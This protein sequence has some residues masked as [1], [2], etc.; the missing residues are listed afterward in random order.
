MIS[1]Y[2]VAKGLVHRTTLLG[3]SVGNFPLPADIRELVTA[4]VPSL[5]DTYFT[6]VY[7]MVYPGIVCQFR[8]MIHTVADLVNNWNIKAS[9]DASCTKHDL[10]MDYDDDNPHHVRLQ[11]MS[12]WTVHLFVNSHGYLGCWMPYEVKIM[13]TTFYSKLPVDVAWTTPTPIVVMQ[14]RPVFALTAYIYTKKQD[15][16]F[17][18]LNEDVVV[19]AGFYRDIAELVACMNKNIRMRGARNG[20]IYHFVIGKHGNMGIEASHRQPEPSFILIKPLT[21]V[22]GMWE[23][24]AHTLH[25]RTNKRYIFENTV[26]RIIF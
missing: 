15:T 11:N 2:D 7:D 25:L 19:P 6:I 23:G 1:F 21:F 13:P 14:D 26:A 3:A 16:D 20:F 22:M 17:Y 8:K 9:Q 5:Q 12:Q 4:P 24:E 18:I 10:I